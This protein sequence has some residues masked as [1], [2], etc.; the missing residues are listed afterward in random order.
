MRVPHY[1]GFL[2]VLASVAMVIGVV[3]ATS[4]TAHAEDAYGTISGTVVGESGLP[5]AG[6]QVDVLTFD[7]PRYPG[8]PYSQ[9]DPAVYTDSTGTY[10]INAPVGD[11]VLRFSKEGLSIS[12]YGGG[13]DLF[14]APRIRTAPSQTIPGIDAVIRRPQLVLDDPYDGGAPFFVKVARASLNSASRRATG[15]PMAGRSR[16]AS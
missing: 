2:S 13:N 14:A 16:R 3:T 9:H 7:D 12:Y 10:S 11:N 15:P 8:Y 1:R 5:E 4:S 6:V